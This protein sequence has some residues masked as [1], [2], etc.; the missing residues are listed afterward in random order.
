MKKPNLLQGAILFAI[1]IMMLL[2]GANIARGANYENAAH[3]VIQPPLPHLRWGQTVKQVEAA[4]YR[5]HH[6]GVG[7]YSILLYPADATPRDKTSHML[8]FDS[9][10]ATARL[11][12]AVV[13]VKLDMSDASATDAMLRLV[14]NHMVEGLHADA[15][16]DLR[17][18][19]LICEAD[20]CMGTLT[21]NS[22]Y[23]VKSG[24]AIV[25]VRS[26]GHGMLLSIMHNP[27]LR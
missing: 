21:E 16:S 5:L 22:H 18:G 26:K 20:M 8:R 19:R 3:N 12:G 1:V 10:A 6:L 17:P 4:G 25:S 9:A 24:L 23:E 7:L 11:A 14:V 27:V 2:I 15:Y 13:Q